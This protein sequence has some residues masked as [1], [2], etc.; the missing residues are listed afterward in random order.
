MSGRRLREVVRMFGSLASNMSPLVVAMSLGHLGDEGSSDGW[1]GLV[2][3]HV[4]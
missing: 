3:C 2:L 1:L 4:Q